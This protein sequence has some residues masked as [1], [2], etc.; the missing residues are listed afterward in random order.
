MSK[1]DQVMSDCFFNVLVMMMMMMV[2]ILWFTVIKKKENNI[3][4]R[5]TKKKAEI[6]SENIL[7]VFFL[8]F[9]T[10]RLSLRPNACLIFFD[11]K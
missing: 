7:V 2:V 10:I 11:E 4:R 6:W 9:V 3:P 8:I 1:S 5:V